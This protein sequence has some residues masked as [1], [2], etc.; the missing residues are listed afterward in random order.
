MMARILGP[1]Q[2]VESLCNTSEKPEP[3]TF[4]AKRVRVAIL[5]SNVDLDSEVFRPYR[6][7][8]KGHFKDFIDDGIMAEMD[9]HGTHVAALLL[10]MAP[11]AE[12]FVGRCFENRER[13]TDV[14]RLILSSSPNSCGQ[15][16]DEQ[17]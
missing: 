8:I 1:G 16:T 9:S 14:R 15:R 6:E 3:S 7:R 5:D 4:I 13:M 17:L 2:S 12:V 10:Q 11:E